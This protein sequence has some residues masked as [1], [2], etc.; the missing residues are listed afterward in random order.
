M[1]TKTSYKHCCHNAGNVTSRKC[2]TLSLIFS[3]KK[4]KDISMLRHYSL[5][6]YGWVQVQLHAFCIDGGNGS[7]L[8]SDCFTPE[9]WPLYASEWITASIW[10]QWRRGKKSLSL[11]GINKTL[12]VAGLILS[13]WFKPP[14]SNIGDE[15]TDC[16]WNIKHVFVV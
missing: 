14:L 16:V 1:K 8:S 11:P 2:S 3:H 6:T 10:T 7:A 9:K 15:M 12:R 5:E 4:G 13:D